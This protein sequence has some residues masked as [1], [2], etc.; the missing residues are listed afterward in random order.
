MTT[1]T[2]GSARIAALQAFARDHLRDTAARFEVASADASF[3]SYWRV[4][5]GGRSHI[6]MNAP[7]DKE[8][9]GPWLDVAARLTGAGVH[10]PSVLAV[11][12]AQGFILMSDLGDRLYLPALTADRVDVLYADALETILA[13]QTRVD[14]AGLPR[15]DRTRLNQEMELLPTWFL[16]RH[17]GVAPGCEGWDCLESTFTRLADSALEQPQSFVHRDFHSRNLL[18]LEADSPGVID[19]QDAVLGPIT[20]DPVSLL[21][22]CY[23]A[24]PEE[25]VDAWSQSHRQRWCDATST[26]IEPEQWRRWFDWMG[27]QRHIK[28]LGIFCRLNYRD[29]KAGYLGDLPL[30]LEYT[31]SVARRYPELR[32]FAEWLAAATAGV[33]LTQPSSG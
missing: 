28:V 24:W 4:H 19:F 25:R 20:Y 29:G 33:P 9:I 22:D 13:M 15:Y 21:R 3:R 31:L 32:P 7:P 30:V 8:D 14:A 6:V 23:I 18:I 10:A 12:R 2:P 1:T 27:L 5:S 17:L 16:Q 26:T 11:D